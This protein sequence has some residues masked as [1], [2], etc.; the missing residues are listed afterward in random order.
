MKRGDATYE[1]WL[2]ALERERAIAAG[3]MVP[4]EPV[5][6]PYNPALAIAGFDKAVRDQLTHLRSGWAQWRTCAER[7][8]PDIRGRRVRPHPPEERGE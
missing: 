8:P 7:D 4:V 2:A 5:R 1:A 3:E 6:P